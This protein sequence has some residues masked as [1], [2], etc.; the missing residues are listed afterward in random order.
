M[1]EFGSKKAKAFR[2]GSKDA[3]K[4]EVNK[5]GVWQTVWMSEPVYDY[6]DG[7]LNTVSGG[8]NGTLY[9]YSAATGDGHIIRTGNPTAWSG[10]FKYVTNWSIPGFTSEQYLGDDR[11][12]SGTNTRNWTVDASGED[13]TVMLF[14][15]YGSS[16]ES[17]YLSSLN[18]TVNGTAYTLQQAVAAGVICPLVLIYSGVDS[19]SYAFPNTQNLYS[20]GSTGTASFASLKVYFMIKKGNKMT[21]FSYWASKAA[22]S[23][24]D[25]SR[26]GAC[27]GDTHRFV[28]SL[29]Q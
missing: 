1:I 14:I 20:G 23:S 18:I 10:N 19:G 29:P 22:G 15:H 3:K 5:N 9:R 13:K 24:A 8:Y 6:G 25:G 7:H 21:S 11:G 4:I 27:S 16:T 28:L 26:A 12:V 2:F 17:I